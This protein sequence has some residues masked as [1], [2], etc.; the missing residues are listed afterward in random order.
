MALG[1]IAVFV[2][3]AGFLVGMESSS[4]GV[5]AT[6]IRAGVLVSYSVKHDMPLEICQAQQVAAKTGVTCSHPTP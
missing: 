1:F 5:I 2:L 3:V 6:M 4:P